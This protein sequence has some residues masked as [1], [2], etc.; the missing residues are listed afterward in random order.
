MLYGINLEL[1]GRKVV[2]I[3][4]GK[5]AERKVDG[6]LEAEAAVT[7]V[8]PNLTAALLKL[9]EEGIIT[10]GAREFSP[11]DLD[12]AFLIFAATND[13]ETNLAVKKSAADHQLVTIVDDPA[14]SDFKVPATVKRGKLS[15]AISTSGASPI[16]AKKIRSQVAHTYDD[17]Y[18]DYLDFLGSCRKEILACVVDSEQ[19]RQL[20]TM[21]AEDDFLEN[22]NREAEFAKLLREAMAQQ[23]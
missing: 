1:S 19:K 15:I 6:L 13:R 10:W 5:V 12:G 2:V 9:A 11:E 14:Q 3:G 21:I 23:E 20:L 17:R 18:A 4:G 8:S 22:E 7:V 16:L